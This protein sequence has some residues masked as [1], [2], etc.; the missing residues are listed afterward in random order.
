MIIDTA[1]LIE[2]LKKRGLIVSNYEEFEYYVN[3]FN[4]NTFI[5]QYSGFF[6]NAN[7]TFDNVDASNIIKLYVFDKNLANH[8]F[9]NILIIEKMMN[10]RVA[11]ETINY[12]D[13][14]DKCLL[15]LNPNILKNSVLRNINEVEPYIDYKAFLFKMVKYL[16]TNKVARSMV[17]YSTHDDIMKWSGVPLD[18]M[19][20]S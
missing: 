20:L 10:T 19:C 13:I 6:E 8:I 17:D 18:L 5:T 15:T 9:R 7:K 1:T 14:K 16:E 11:V 12:F 2:Q 3:N 4:V